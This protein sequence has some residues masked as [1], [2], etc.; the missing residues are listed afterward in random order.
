M[1]SDLLF[2]DGL[3]KKRLSRE[4]V[5]HESIAM[6]RETANSSTIIVDPLFTTAILLPPS[7]RFAM[8]VRL[9]GITHSRRMICHS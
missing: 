3:D 1:D 7:C 5:F 9:C 6:L 8:C 2:L 4:I